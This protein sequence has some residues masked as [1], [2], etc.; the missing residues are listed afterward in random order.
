MSVKEMTCEECQQMLEEYFD[1]ELQQP[2]AA[3]VSAHVDRCAQCRSTLDQLQTEHRLF[4][5]YDRELELRPALWAGV[6]T[7]VAEGTQTNTRTQTRWATFSMLFS[8]MRLN[9]PVTVGLILIA[10]GLT[11]A[12][13]KYFERPA[14]QIAVQTAQPPATVQ[15]PEPAKE[16]SAVHE[17]LPSERIAIRHVKPRAETGR[18]GI[19]NAPQT[20]SALVREAELK[21]LS[22]IAMLTRDVQEHPARL[23][24][25]AR[26]RLDDALSAI[27][28]TIASTRRAVRRNPDDPV[29]VQYMLSAYRK[30][31]DVL[32]EMTNY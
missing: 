5:S 9:V 8:E 14:N 21:Y 23:D 17:S 6:Q 11:V 30:K 10:V 2:A 13:M 15:L 27:D 28:R 25:G 26:V 16:K 1:G 22:A 29:A 19:V 12:F 20:A 24:Q 7:R 4:L 31:V 32:R 18:R 3:D